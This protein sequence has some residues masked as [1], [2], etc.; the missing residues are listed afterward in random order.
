MACADLDPA[1]SPEMQAEV[2]RTIARTGEVPAAIAQ[3]TEP[4][5]LTDIAA[6]LR[7]VPA[8]HR[9]ESVRDLHAAFFADAYAQRE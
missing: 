1:L 6:E 3:P 7:R 8:A 4:P 9:S 2:A 5:P